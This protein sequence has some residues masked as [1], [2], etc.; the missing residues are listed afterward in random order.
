MA[1][2]SIEDDEI[3]L[4]KAMLSR[5]MKN[6]DIQFFFNRPD[7]SVNSGRI[8]GIRTGTYGPSKDIAA[9]PDDALDSFIAGH[10]GSPVPA[11]GEVSSDPLAE[12]TIRRLFVKGKDGV[13]RLNVGE[14]D[15][16]ECKTSFGTKHAHVWLRAIA[17]LANNR[18]GYIFFGVN[19]KGSDEHVV[20]GMSSDEFKKVDPATLTQRVKAVFDPTPR[21]RTT[22]MAIGGKQVGVI[23]VE[24]HDS[25]PVIATK[26]EGDNINEGDIFFRYPGQSTRI[27]YSDLRA[28]LDARDREARA[29]ILPL[30]ERLLQLGPQRSL[31]A[32]LEEG[33]LSD[34]KT[35]IYIDENL[36]A[37]LNFIKEGQFNEVHGAPTLRL[38]GEV[39]PATSQASI[40]T[41]FGLLTRANVLNDFLNQKNPDK[42]ELYIRVAVEIGQGGWFPLH[43][44]ARLAGMTQAQLVD[45]INS[46][47]GTPASKATYIRRA[48]PRAAYKKV[49]GKPK[50][51]LSAIMAG[52]LPT[53]TSA[54]EASHVSQAIQA[55]PDDFEFDRQA[56]LSLLK[57]CLALLTG[58]STLSF[59]KRAICRVDEILYSEG[60][61]PEL[62]LDNG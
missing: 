43:Y 9:A 36:I 62:Q 29:Q 7:R 10:Q 18:G 21:F 54:L 61:D 24:R 52:D 22:I 27:K 58:K 4:I 1:K 45:F 16:H 49:A 26:R 56:M 3:A 35:A 14:T 19:D 15:C 30:V 12:A 46:T 59:L 41:E 53:V 44:F 28:M 25:R 60:S 23:Y 8:T 32:D 20:V 6:K 11:S 39:Q 17:A 51:Y 57:A 40:K 47:D 38:V 50:A 37:K 55:L 13:W 31:I 42:P 48:Q 34:G 33:T 5:G 2:R